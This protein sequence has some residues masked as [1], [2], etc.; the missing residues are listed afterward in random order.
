MPKIRG[1]V[2]VSATASASDIRTI[3]ALLKTNEYYED[4]IT[5]LGLEATVIDLRR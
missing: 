4:L 1:V 3:G 2:S 5:S